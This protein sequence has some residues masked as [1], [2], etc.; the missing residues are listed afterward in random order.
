MSLGTVVIVGCNKPYTGPRKEGLEVWG[1]NRIFQVQERIDRLFALDPLTR[2]YFNEAKKRE[3]LAGVSSRAKRVYLQT[4]EESIPNSEAYPLEKVL[5]K[6][7]VPY[8]TSSISYM[9]ALAICEGAEKI[10]LW[11]LYVMPGSLEYLGQKACIEFWVGQAIG[12]GIKVEISSDSHLCR[13]APWQPELYAYNDYVGEDYVGKM[14]ASATR[15]AMGIPVQ[16]GEHA[17]ADHFRE[18]IPQEVVRIPVE[19]EQQD[20]EEGAQAIAD[21]RPTLATYR[22]PGG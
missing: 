9:L 12:R 16:F 1:C 14:Q 6:L 13:P 7:G 8:F 10:V 18:T 4:R 21:M 20:A 2:F 3:F 5:T 22:S 11:R 17:V 15:I 19:D